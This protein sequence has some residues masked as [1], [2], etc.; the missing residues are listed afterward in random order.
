MFFPLA[1]SL[2]ESAKNQLALK[3]VCVMIEQAIWLNVHSVPIPV[4]EI[5]VQDGY[6]ARWSADGRQ[7]NFV[8]AQST[9]LSN[10]LRGTGMP[11]IPLSQMSLVGDLYVC[12]RDSF[13]DF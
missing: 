8:G 2:T 5:R 9:T 1:S 11:Y 4:F 12:C 7:V 13:E 10:S 3:M 6:G